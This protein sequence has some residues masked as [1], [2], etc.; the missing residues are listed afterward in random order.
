M[1]DLRMVGYAR[2]YHESL[3]GEKRTVLV[4]RQLSVPIVLPQLEMLPES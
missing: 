3:A 4:Q 2:T 1:R